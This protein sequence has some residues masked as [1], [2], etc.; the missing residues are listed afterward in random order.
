MRRTLVADDHPALRAA[1]AHVLPAHGFEIAGEAADGRR[2]VSLAEELQ[3]E[4]AL[5][6]LGLPWLDGTDLIRALHEVAP[7][8]RIAVY[9]ADADEKLAREVLQAGALALV[10]KESPVA[11]LVRALESTVSGASFLDPTIGRATASASLTQREL[12]VLA[13][14]AEGLHHQ[15]IGNRLGISC[16]TVRTHLRK[17]GTRLGA[18]TRTQAVATAIR[19]GLLK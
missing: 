6:D 13:L 17:A 5:I 18:Q 14:L 8:M 11:D 15:E 1:V 4:V 2:A 10:L 9:T 19:S 3:P 12:D 7:E 16:E